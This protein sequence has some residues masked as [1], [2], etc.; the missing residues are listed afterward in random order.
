MIRKM[1]PSEKINSGGKS[2]DRYFFRMQL[3][4]QPFLQKS[5]YLWYL[6]LKPFSILMQKDKIVRITDI[7]TSFERVLYKLIKY[8]H[9]DIG[10][11]L[12]G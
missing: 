1:D 2:A 6:P 11:E 8:I 5:P 10:K 9:V 4:M 12:G 7:I 3:Q